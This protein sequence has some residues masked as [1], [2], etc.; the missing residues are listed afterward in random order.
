MNAYLESV[1]G[2]DATDMGEGLGKIDGGKKRWRLL[3]MYSLL[4][5]KLG[6]H[7]DSSNEPSHFVVSLKHELC[8]YQQPPCGRPAHLCV[9]P[10]PPHVSE[11][12]HLAGPKH[13]SCVDLFVLCCD[14]R[15]G[16]VHMFQ[17]T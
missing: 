12:A 5:W 7:S 3:S 1:S 15:K 17:G 10:I 8:L 14:K 2:E 9:V 11:S 4:S 13:G 16:Q 6:L